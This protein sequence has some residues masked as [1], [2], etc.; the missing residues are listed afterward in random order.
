VWSGEK[1]ILELT[2]EMGLREWI[3]Q[4]WVRYQ[5][6]LLELANF[7]LRDRDWAQEVVQDTWVDFL[8]S[9]TRFEGRCSP[10]T[11]L[12]QIL[13]RRI[14]K[15]L[16][17]MILRR[18][19]E[20]FLEIAKGPRHHEVDAG[21]PSFINPVENPE[22]SLLMQERLEYI[23]RVSRTLPQRQAEVWILRDL[24][25]WTSEDVSTALNITRENQR[26]LLHRARQRLKKQLEPYFGQTPGSS[27]TLG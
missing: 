7:Q 17:R 5:G 2:G 18:A 16:R 13:R 3:T 14:K 23:L 1:E 21:L 12:V 26:I 9:L 4:L 24:N 6:L 19:R 15:E 20:A 22:K 11:W 8:K 27:S 10:K 25:Q